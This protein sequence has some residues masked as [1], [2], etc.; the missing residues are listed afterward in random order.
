MKGKLHQ[1]AVVFASSNYTELYADG[2]L[3]G[4]SRVGFALSAIDD[5]NDWI[6]RS[7]WTNDHTFAGIIDEFRIYGRSLSPCEIADLNAAGPNSP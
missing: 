1:V 2:M 3:M 4:R 5:V 7:Q 6:G